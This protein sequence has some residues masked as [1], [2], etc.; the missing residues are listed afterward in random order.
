[1]LRTSRVVEPPE[2]VERH[3]QVRELYALVRPVAVFSMKRQR[4][5]VA[6]AGLAEPAER[7]E[8]SAELTGGDGMSRWIAE[9]FEQGTRAFGMHQ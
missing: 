5:L 2:T 8:A 7:C 3:A 1:M 6:R 4:A 9:A